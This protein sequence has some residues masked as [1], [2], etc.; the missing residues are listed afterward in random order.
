[1]PAFKNPFDPEVRLG[2]SCGAHASKSEHDQSG[3]VILLAD[4]ILPMSNGPNARIAEVVEN[5][6]PRPGV[7]SGGESSAKIINL[8]H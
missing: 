6:P 3:E 7:D 4:R 1:M 2:C 5:T 8:R